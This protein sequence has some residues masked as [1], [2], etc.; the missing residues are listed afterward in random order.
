MVG[1]VSSPIVS[2]SRDHRRQLAI[3][4]LLTFAA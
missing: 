3:V 4:A 1:G 2:M